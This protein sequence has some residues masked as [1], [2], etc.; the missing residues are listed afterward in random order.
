MTHL[1]REEWKH[2]ALA[3]LDGLRTL[4]TNDAPDQL[5]IATIISLFLSAWGRLGDKFAQHLG[6]H[7][8]NY[9]RQYVGLYAENAT[10]N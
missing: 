9:A 7:L 8:T 2:R 3:K 6:N 1:Q 10:E 5:V 4:I